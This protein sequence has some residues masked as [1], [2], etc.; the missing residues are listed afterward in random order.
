[1]FSDLMLDAALGI[2]LFAVV[3]VAAVILALLIVL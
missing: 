2:M 1:V 3:S